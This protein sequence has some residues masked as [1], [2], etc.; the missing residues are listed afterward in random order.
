[1]EEGVSP[2]ELIEGGRRREDLGLESDAL[3]CLRNAESARMVAHLIS[4]N[5]SSIVR[6]VKSHP[7]ED[8]LLLSVRRARSKSLPNTSCPSTASKT[9]PTYVMLC[10]VMLCYVIVCYVML[11]YVMS[12]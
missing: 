10:Y 12:C 8:N 7:V 6:N 11:C 2:T 4:R 1:V 3:L 9:S 5:F